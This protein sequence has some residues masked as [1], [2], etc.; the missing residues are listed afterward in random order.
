MNPPSTPAQGIST[1]DTLIV[2]TLTH[3]EQFSFLRHVFETYSKSGI[4]PENLPIAADTYLALSRARE[5][6]VKQD[7]GKAR[8]TDFGPNGI[9]LEFDPQDEAA[10]IENMAI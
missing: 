7:L 6:P 1:G 8:I 4:Q 10:R 5:I 9:A 3:P 2:I